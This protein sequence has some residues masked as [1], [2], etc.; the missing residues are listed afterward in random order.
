M[1][2]IAKL[3]FH[4]NEFETATS[5]ASRFSRYCGLDGPRDLCLD[6]GF[7]WQEL[8][9]GDD[10]ALDGLAAITGED[11]TRVR[12]WAVRN[13]G[14][15]RFN[16]AGFPAS[17]NAVL[18]TRVRLCPLCLKEDEE[19]F[20]SNGIYR[21]CFWQMSGIRTCP[22][23]ATPLINLP[24][25]VHTILNYDYIHK[26]Q[27]HRAMIEAAIREAPTLRTE[28]TG[29]EEDVWHRTRGM[30]QIPFLDDLTLD[31]ACKLC[32]TLGFVLQFG[33]ERKLRTASEYELWQSA[34]QGFEA[35]REGEAGLKGALL[36]LRTK[37]SF[38]MGGY[39]KDLG[40]FYVWLHGSSLKKEMIPLRDL[41]RDLIAQNYPVSGARTV[42]G[43]PCPESPVYSV[44]AGLKALGIKRSRMHEHLIEQGLATPV[45][46]GNSVELHRQIVERDLRAFEEGAGKRLTSQ[47]AAQFLNVSKDLVL[48]LKVA[49]LIETIDDSYCRGPRYHQDRLTELLNQLETCL[50]APSPDETYIPLN[51]AASRLKRK[52]PVIIRLLLVGKILATK[53]GDSTGFGRI[54]IGLNSSRT[55]LHST[56]QPGLTRSDTAVKLHVKH[57]TISWLIEEGLLQDVDMR[58][59]RSGQHITA[60]CKGSIKVFLQ[61]HITL[62]LLAKQLNRKP[63]PLGC[64]LDGKRIWPME[65]P[66]NL[67]RIYK[68]SRLERQLQELG[69]GLS[70]KQP[71]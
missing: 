56:N 35:L 64:F 22:D 60:I 12:R 57:Q 23:H 21:R 71:A 49:G 13:V 41:I 17:G 32:E 52:T 51:E 46:E 43:K 2:P 16:I 3:Q 37:Q 69:M 65:M 26:V 7:R 62:G 25:D 38:H 47:Q 34:Q 31:V 14:A 5:F 6:Q 18:R 9:A 1:K 50:T 45:S 39:N 44:S 59:A 8:I 70:V 28:Y 29:F 40:A 10:F 15:K 20:G 61:D 42:L 33:A 53:D 19:R 48:E 58:S 30:K 63:G 11:P 68:R 36:S 66:D 4:I 55:V 67:S 54:K 27:K 24:V